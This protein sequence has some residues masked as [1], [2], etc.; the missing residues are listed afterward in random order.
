[1]D[2]LKHHVKQER[3]FTRPKYRE[4]KTPR[5]VRVYSVINE[6]KYLL[7]TNVPTINVDAELRK[8][9]C[10]YGPIEE[11]KVLHEYPSDEFHEAVLIKF[12]K[13]QNARYHT[14]KLINF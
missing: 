8:L 1:M 12:N 5:S 6:S 10:V 13:I 3:C 7:V 14:L 2:V 4:G 11:H 9:F